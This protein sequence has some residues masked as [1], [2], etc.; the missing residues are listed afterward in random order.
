MVKLSLWLAGALLLTVLSVNA[1][2]LDADLAVHQVDIDHRFAGLDILMFGARNDVGQVVVTL[3]GQDKTYIVRKKA[4]IG[5]IWV[6]HEQVTFSGVPNFYAL[7]THGEL[8]NVNNMQLLQSVGVGQENLNFEV[9]DH[10]DGVDQK[11]FRGALVKELQ[12]KQLYSYEV[13]PLSFWGETLFRTV[14]EFPK[15]VERGNYTAEV[16]LFNGG[17]LS[18]MQSTPIGVRKVGF[19]A[20]LYDLAHK[21]SWVYGALAVFLAIFCGWTANLALRRLA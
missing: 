17:V 13:Q 19:E 5:G 8:K 21:S 6:N 7:A 4:R 20:F 9:V 14:L 15:T 2:P 11:D 1:R 10:S 18:G 3:R 16:F 12:A